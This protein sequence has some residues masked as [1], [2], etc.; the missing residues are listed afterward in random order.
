MTSVPVPIGVQVDLNSG[1]SDG[2]GRK[3]ERRDGYENRTESYFGDV[4][5]RD[6]EVL[7]PYPREKPCFK[8]LR[9]TRSTEYGH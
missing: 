2:P 5:R 4:N 3:E 7:F 9:S 1:I 8:F 6:Q